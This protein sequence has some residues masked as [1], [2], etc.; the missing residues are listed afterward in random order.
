M[1]LVRL[2]AAGSVDDGKSTLIG[3]LLFDTDQV[4]QDTLESIQK[5]S[6]G[7]Q[8]DLALITDGL[9]SEREQK[10]TI[11]VAYRYFSTSKRRF[12]VAD[13]PGHEQYTRN[14]V[15]GA[16]QANVALLLV[17]ARK[18]LLVQTKRHL[19]VCSLLGIRHVC[20]VI[21]KMDMVNYAKETFDAI[22]QDI[23][24]FAKKLAIADFDFIPAS[25]YAGDM[26]VKRGDALS[27]YDGYTV[28]EYLNSVSLAGDKNHVDARFP[29]QY[30]LRPNQDFRGYA[31]TMESGQ[32]RV[33]EEVT[34]LPS[35]MQ[36]TIK[37]LY[38]DDTSIAEVHAGQA[39]VIELD[40][41]YD[42]S[43]GDM[44][45]R[46]KNQ[47]VVTASLDAMISWFDLK[48]LQPHKRYLLKH[49]TK[50]VPATIESIT[51]VLNI[52]TLHREHV[53]TVG[54]NDIARVSLCLGQPI[55]ADVY[56]T[57]QMT[58]S[59]ILVDPDT[60]RTVAAGMIRDVSA[61]KTDTQPVQLSSQK[62]QVL[63]FTG[64]SGAGKSTL[65]DAL[66]ERLQ[67]KGMAVERLDGD[68]LR[69]HVTGDLGF[70]KKDRELNVRIAAFSADKLA[71]HGV[72]VLATFISPYQAQ[73]DSLKDWVHNF[74]EIYV[75][76]SLDVCETRDVKGLYKQAREG[77][78]TQF[79]GIDD[80]YE[81]PTDPDCVI[82]TTD[83]SIASS[84]EDLLV[85]LGIE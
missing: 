45:V 49:T 60:A 80:P 81:P 26:V 52:D 13:V 84:V 55:M 6:E 30:V 62:G 35:G 36:T 67:K 83:K 31:G 48:T 8:V 29:V 28:L 20:V 68:D 54:L 77:K 18:G 82:D 53:Q 47:P 79:T 74:R 50:E 32:L 22:V 51:Y 41:Q 72:T 69:E 75:S 71:R 61:P 9:S 57:N 37:A 64:L 46:T 11:D 76:T 12:I 2:V 10:I 23:E 78:I 1:D 58:G 34:L 63:W 21:N 70:S 56:Q 27:W 66:Y 44:I 17:D 42:V 4:P 15:T 85:Q 59:F 39:V 7:D 40:G 73:R 14:M 33:N 24:Q 25:A 65:A 16:S 3:R 43:R 19:T 38:V 5:A